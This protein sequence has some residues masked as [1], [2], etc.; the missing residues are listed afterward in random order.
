MA[1]GLGYTR[2]WAVLFAMAM[3]GLLLLAS[4]AEARSRCKFGQIYRPSL[5][6]CQAKSSKSAQPYIK[7]QTA[8]PKVVVRERVIVKEVVREK[9]PEPVSTIPL[10]EP[11]AQGSLNPLPRWKPDL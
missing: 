11:K 5:R 3:G 7:K 1:H 10:R 8:A 4:A 6:A 2:R 9:D